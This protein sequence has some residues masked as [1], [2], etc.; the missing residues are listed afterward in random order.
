MDAATF[1]FIRHRA[2]LE[3]SREESWFRQ[4]L[5]R[6]IENSA[7]GQQQLRLAADAFVRAA[8]KL[9]MQ[10]MQGS[11]RLLRKAEEILAQPPQR[12]PRRRKP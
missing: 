11:P 7:R 6:K 12:Y 2:E 3:Y 1:W 9:R 5:N 4:M 10:G 8:R